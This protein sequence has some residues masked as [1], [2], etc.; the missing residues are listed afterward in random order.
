M[1][2]SSALPRHELAD[3]ALS[4]ADAAGASY[5]DLRIHRITTEIVQ[6]R[7][8]ELETVGPQPRDRLGGA[9]DRRRH[10]G[11]RLARRARPRGR[12]RHRATGR[13][14]GHHAGAAERRAHR[15]GR[16]AGLR[17]RDAGCRTT[18]ST[19]S[20]VPAAGQDRACSDEYSGRLLAADGVDHVSAG[21]YAVKEQTFYA[22]TFGSSTTQQRVRL[23]PTLEAVAVDAA[24]GTFE[25][26]RTLAPPTARGWEVVAGDDVWN[27]STSWRSCRRCWPRRP[28]RPAWWPADRFGDRP[29]QPVADHPRI[30]R[31]RH[32]IRPSHRLRGRLR[33]YL[34]RHAGQAEHDAATAPR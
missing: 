34:V 10:V 15:A 2:T 11:L 17:R 26:M 27:W 24:A 7:D 22:D 33:G 28:R 13:A 14:G 3:A 25:T 23:Q 31:P 19:R 9:G 1:P 30:H 29:D 21:L 4:A 6:L 16:R 8:G 32:R 5:A 18:G 20:S 12:R